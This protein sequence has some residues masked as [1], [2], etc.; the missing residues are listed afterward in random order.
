MKMLGCCVETTARRQREVGQPP[1]WLP[2][3]L[4]VTSHTWENSKNEKSHQ[5]PTIG[6]ALG[7]MS[8][9]A[10]V[11]FCRWQYRGRRAARRSCRARPG[12]LVVCPSARRRGLRRGAAQRLRATAARS[13]IRWRP[14]QLVAIGAYQPTPRSPRSATCRA[15]PARLRERGAR[16]R[17]PR[18]PRDAIEAAFVVD[19]ARVRRCSRRSR[20]ACSSATPAPSRCWA[21][22]DASTRPRAHACWATSA[23][24]V[25]PTPGMLSANR[26]TW[27]HAVDACTAVAGWPREELLD[28]AARR[29]RRPRR[30]ARAAGQG[31]MS[32]VAPP[33]PRRRCA[34]RACSRTR[35]TSRSR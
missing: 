22:C 10:R 34:P 21:C 30:S 31:A 25:R 33:P 13:S 7:E 1:R 35:R 19:D 12:R 17:R 11:L 26:C 18:V 5:D 27:A 32:V 29:A 20:R 9:T 14:T 8:D 16:A 2:V 28:A 6:E 15:R 3:L 4:V 23:A 24:A